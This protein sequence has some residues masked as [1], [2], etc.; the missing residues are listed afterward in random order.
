MSDAIVLTAHG[1]VDDL[2]DM[3][4]FLARIRHGRP[5]PPGLVEELKH[6]YRAIGGSPL[7]RTTEVQADLLARAVGKPVF[8]GMRLWRPELR[9][10]LARAIAGG[11][12]RICVLPLAPYSVH[13]YARAAEQALGELS[14]DGSVTLVAAQP[15]GAEPEFIAAH[16]EALEPFLRGR[17]QSETELILTAH[18]LPMAVIRGGDPYA[19]LVETSAE[20]IGAVLGWNYK[21]AYQS[22]GADGGEWLG[23]DLGQVLRESRAHRRRRVVVAPV[24]FLC[25]HVETLYDL[26]VEARAQAAGLELDF[27]RVP[28]LNASPRLIQALAAVVERTLSR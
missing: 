15:F 8:V 7:L 9:D 13:V 19:R 21:L 1:S 6:R 24:G 18:S 11:A 2:Q 5:A 12:T 23:P 16:V 14:P 3:P 26:D 10:A 22:Q 20:R 27:E 17:A 25:D 28:A 4:A